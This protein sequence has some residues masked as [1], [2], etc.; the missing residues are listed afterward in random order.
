MA[1]SHFSKSY[2][3]ALVVL[4]IL[5]CRM[6]VWAGNYQVQ[7]SIPASHELFSVVVDDQAGARVRNLVA[8]GD[9]TALG[10]AAADGGQRTVTVSWDGLNDTGDPVPTGTYR[11]RGLSLPKLRATFDYA[12][13]N[14]GSPPWLGYPN[15]GWGGDHSGQTGIACVPAEA[16]SPWHVIITGEIGEGGDSVFALD[17]AGNKVFGFKRGWGGSR[18]V[19]IDNG[20]AYLTLWGENTLFRLSCST[21]RIQ[22][23]QRRA[24]VIDEVRLPGRGH[25]IAVGKDHVA[26][27]IAPDSQHGPTSPKLLF[28]SKDEGR[29]QDTL[30]F[31]ALGW[32]A[33]GPDGQFFYSGDV[34]V[35]Y[36]NDGGMYTAQRCYYHATENTTVSDLPTEAELRPAQWKHV[37]VR[38]PGGDRNC[39][40]EGE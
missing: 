13:Y 40:E 28:I 2:P 37:M 16:N 12:W 8:M 15:S 6:T 17:Q 24:G 11:A 35:L 39:A 19:A 33:S 7:F 32:I 3:F 31:P 18:Q 38:K 5:F 26:V 25:D 29:I 4:V 9:A 34:G 36:S 21:G 27:L 22:P 20:L 10:K 14:P 1:H 30:D 23:F